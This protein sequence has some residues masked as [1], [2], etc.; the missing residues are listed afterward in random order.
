MHYNYV[1]TICNGMSLFTRYRENV[2]KYY[3]GETGR[4]IVNRI[5]NMVGFELRNRDRCVFVLSRAWKRKN[6]ESPW[7]IEPQTF[8]LRA[9]MRFMTLS[10]PLILALYRT[11]VIYELC[12]RV[13]VAQW[14]NIGA[15]NP[16][17]WG[18]IAHGDSEFFVCPTLLRRVIVERIE[19][20]EINTRLARTQNSMISENATETGHAPVWI[21]VMFID[22]ASHR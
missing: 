5:R 16:K 3:I 20:H 12:Y 19:E 11:C 2:A 1:S 22:H 10:T 4:V 7:G 14:W 17:V 18:W 6:S 8:E 21:H 15:R 9:S 13:S